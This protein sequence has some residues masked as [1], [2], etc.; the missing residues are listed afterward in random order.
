MSQSAGLWYA[1][2][3]VDVKFIA[4]TRDTNFPPNLGVIS[5]FYGLECWHETIFMLIIQNH[6]L[7]CDLHEYL[8]LEIR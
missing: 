4:Y 7:T 8:A 2:S 1:E 5:K 6:G 3:A